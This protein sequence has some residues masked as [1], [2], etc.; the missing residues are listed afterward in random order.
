MDYQKLVRD[1]LRE[2]P[3]AQKELYEHF[4]PLMLGICYRYTKSL[5]DAEDVL[6]EVRDAKCGRKGVG[7]G[8]VPKVMSKDSLAYQP[9]DP[10]D[11][12]SSAYEES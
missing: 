1:C 2:Q 12:D 6:Q 10:T 3:A 9:N 8:G 4:A 7:G 11:K 5:A